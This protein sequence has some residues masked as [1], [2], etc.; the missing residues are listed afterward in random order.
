MAEDYKPDTVIDI[1]DTHTPE[2]DPQAAQ[3]GQ[4]EAQTEVLIGKVVQMV[5]RPHGFQKGQSGNPNG[6]PKGAPNK[7]TTEV[8]AV[9]NMLVDD[10]EYREMLRQRLI[11]GTAPHMEPLLWAYAKG[12]PVD[13]VESGGPGAFAALDD[14]QLRSRLVEALDALKTGTE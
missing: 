8:K 11:K 2:D 10:P 9:A 6:R 7:S 5:K 4:G 13:R 14:D 12:K 3:E 1:T